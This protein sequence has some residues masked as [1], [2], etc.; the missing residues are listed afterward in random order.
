MVH[1]KYTKLITE[2]S[3]PCRSDAFLV[4]QSVLEPSVT[5]SISV[6]VVVGWVVFFF[7]GGGAYVK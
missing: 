7:L 4:T 1:I 5:D 3:S 2:K 6:C